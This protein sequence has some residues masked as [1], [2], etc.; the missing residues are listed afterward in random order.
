MPYKGIKENS[1]SAK[2]VA[3]RP[4]G[5]GHVQVRPTG[6]ER[7]KQHILIWLDSVSCGPP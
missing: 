6:S 2:D 7:A 4:T 5:T 1:V 3:V